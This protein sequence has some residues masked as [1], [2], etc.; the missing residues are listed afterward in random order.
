MLIDV[1]KRYGGMALPTGHIILEDEKALKMLKDFL[2][3]T[4][5]HT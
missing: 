5:P 3:K 4:K 2:G 1:S